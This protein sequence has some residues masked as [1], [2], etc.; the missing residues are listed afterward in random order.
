MNKGISTYFISVGK[1]HT[2]DERLAQF[3]LPHG[4][5]FG[6]RSTEMETS[7]GAFD[8]HLYGVGVFSEAPGGW[9]W[10]C[11]GFRGEAKA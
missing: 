6:P 5:D 9:M 2:K 8:D 10:R 1:V 4:G 11:S 3:L 7:Q